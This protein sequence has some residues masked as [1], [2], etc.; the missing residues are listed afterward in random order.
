MGI[1]VVEVQEPGGVAAEERISRLERG[2]AELL[3]DRVGVDPV[4]VESLEH[5]QSGVEEGL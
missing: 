2:R 3:G 5:V 4:R 1:E